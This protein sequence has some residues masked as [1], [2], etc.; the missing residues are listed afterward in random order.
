VRRDIAWHPIEADELSLPQFLVGG[1]GT[2]LAVPAFLP[3]C[4]LMWF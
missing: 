3:Q 2:D 4:V 1:Q